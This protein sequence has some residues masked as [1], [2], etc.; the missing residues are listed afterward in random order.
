MNCPKQLLYK[1]SNCRVTNSDLY[2]TSRHNPSLSEM[3]CCKLVQD[4][5][6]QKARIKRGEVS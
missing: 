4:Y 5:R 3:L 1:I 2:H 6:K